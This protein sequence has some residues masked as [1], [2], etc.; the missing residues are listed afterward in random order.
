[1]QKVIK[2]SRALLLMLAF[3]L[4]FAPMSALAGTGEK[5][6]VNYVALGDSLAKGTLNSNEPSGG[7]VGNIVNDLKLRGYDVNLTN[8]GEN[9]YKTDDVLGGLGEIT[10][11]LATADLIT[12]SVGA[13]DVL[14]DLIGLIKANPDLLAS[15]KPEYMTP[16]GIA[17]LQ[18]AAVAAEI[19]AKTAESAAVTAVETAQADIG[20]A[21][22][23]IDGVAVT[24]VPL[25]ASLKALLEGTPFWG[26]AEQKIIELEVA[27]AKAVS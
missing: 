27:I 22:T 25:I 1:M 2:Q 16:E 5:P 6:T 20:T 9:G 15:F 24:S 14:T 3:L 23:S 7:Y 18:Q 19:V 21:K 4:V 10:S 13:N 17:Q 12:I 8:K 26:I 11:E